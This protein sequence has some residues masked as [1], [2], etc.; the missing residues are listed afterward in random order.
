MQR[1]GH[2]RE[3]PQ[4]GTVRRIGRRRLLQGQGLLQP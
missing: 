1:R 4:D 3:E 2:G